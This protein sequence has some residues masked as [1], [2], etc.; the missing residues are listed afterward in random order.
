MHVKIILSFACG[1]KFSDVRSSNLISNHKKFF[2]KKD[3][4]QKN[5]IQLLLPQKKN[6]VISLKL[7]KLFMHH[8]LHRN[9]FHKNH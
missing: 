2:L 8:S 5:L 4:N 1:K 6:I 7:L 9:H 3:T